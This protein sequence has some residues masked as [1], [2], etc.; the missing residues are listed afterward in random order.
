[1]LGDTITITVNAVARVLSKIN[2]DNFAAEYLLRTATEEFRVNVR[3]ST[4]SAKVGIRPF[5]RHNFELRHTVF[6]TLTVAEVIR[7][8]ATTIRC[9]KGDDP[10]A[11]VLTAKGETAWLSDANLAKLVAW[12]S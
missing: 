10:A 11:V 5:E 1:M 7:I 9:M 12:E 6:A 4:E 2:Q 8:T 3:H